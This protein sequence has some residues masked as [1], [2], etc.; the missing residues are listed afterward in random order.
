MPRV[1]RGANHLSAAEID[2]R[3]KQATHHWH[4]LAW[5]VILTAHEDPRP[6][7]MIARQLYVSKDFVHNV[8]ARYNREGPT[9]ITP[10]APT[11][12]R[13][14]YL[15]RDEE[16]QFLAPFFERAQRGDI[17]TAREI[18][19]AYE[20]RVGRTVAESTISRLLKRHG[21]RKVTPRPRH[22]NSDP[23][24]QAAFQAACADQVVAAV[25]TRTADDTRPV[26]V[27]AQ[28]EGRF[29]R[30]SRPQRCWAPKGVRPS[31]PQ[32]LVRDLYVCL[33]RRCAELGT[34]DLTHLTPD[35]HHDDESVSG[36][37]RGD[38]SRLFYR[39]AGRSSGMASVETPQNPGEHA[40]RTPTGPQPR[41]Q[42]GGTY[43]GLFAGKRP[44]QPAVW[45]L[46]KGDCCIG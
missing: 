2:Q 16:R 14:Q 30:I 21:W 7:A 41:T 5:Q 31:V 42:S 10:P 26:V 20:E 43:L 39:D 35:Q 3:I 38:V 13:H 28:D 25:A 27:M 6:A 11:K 36:A 34:D 32:Q 22:P 37:C 33:H 24:E 12:P 45:L 17:I 40:A 4:R 29:G 44:A 19:R 15:A 9:A 18:Q 8:I 23:E 1:T 46:E